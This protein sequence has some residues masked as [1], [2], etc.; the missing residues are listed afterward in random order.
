MRYHGVYEREHLLLRPNIKVVYLVRYV[1]HL[2]Q[3]LG[4]GLLC[5]ANHFLLYLKEAR[6]LL[7]IFAAYIHLEKEVLELLVRHLLYIV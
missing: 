3:G 4:V 2:Q 1:N 7:S 6:G 5:L